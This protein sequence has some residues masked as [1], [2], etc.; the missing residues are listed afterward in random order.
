MHK[1]FAASAALTILLLLP[2]TGYPQS[3]SPSAPDKSPAKATP[4]PDYS[5]MPPAKIIDKLQEQIIGWQDDIMKGM[6]EQGAV[7]ILYRDMIGAAVDSTTGEVKDQKLLDL[8]SKYGI[9]ISTKDGKKLNT[10]ADPASFYKAPPVTAP[11]IEVKEAATHEE[12]ARIHALEEKSQTLVDRVTQARLITFRLETVTMDL[13]QLSK[14]D[15]S[16]KSLVEKYHIKMSGPA[17]SASPAP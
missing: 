8:L 12:K 1:K 2:A 16:A 15:D 6:E 17:P 7:Q 10:V 3:P 13:L 9:G 11:F 5:T 4:A 14:T